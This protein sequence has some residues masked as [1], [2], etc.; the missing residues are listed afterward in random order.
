MMMAAGFLFDILFR[1]DHFQILRGRHVFMFR[2]KPRKV[3]H[4]TE[5]EFVRDLRE[6]L[7]VFP[8]HLFCKFQSLFIDIIDRRAVQIVAEQ[9]A[10]CRLVRREQKGQFRQRQFLRQM[11]FDIMADLRQKGIFA[12]DQIRRRVGRR[13]VGAF[14]LLRFVFADEFDKKVFQLALGKLVGPERKVF[15]LFHVFEIGYI[16]GRKKYA[17]AFLDDL[18][19]EP[20]VLQRQS[21]RLLREKIQPR[22]VAF[23][24]DDDHARR[25]TEVARKHMLFIGQVQNKLLRAQNALIVFR[26]YVHFAPVDVHEFV[27]GMVI[28]LRVVIADKFKVVHVCDAGDIQIILYRL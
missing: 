24:S 1:F 6:R 11:L 13:C 26:L 7:V 16:V 17:A 10:Q 5:I 20:L 18:A 22:A 27:K 9:R 15:A 21:D 14:A 12:R 19:E 25:R 3:M 28:A 23:E 4:R 8:H 2:K